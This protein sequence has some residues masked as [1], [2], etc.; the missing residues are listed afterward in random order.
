MDQLEK[1]LSQNDS[2]VN[3]LSRNFSNISLVS[4]VN[5]RLLRVYLRN[6]WL[7][8]YGGGVSMLYLS[9]IFLETQAQGAIGSAKLHSL[10]RLCGIL[11]APCSC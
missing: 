7:I 2:Q 1:I 11:V 6:I 4:N 5:L 10:K 9:S 3:R 8:C